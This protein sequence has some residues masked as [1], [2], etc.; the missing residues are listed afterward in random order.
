MTKTPDKLYIAVRADIPP[1]LQM[2]QA[3]HAAFEFSH[4]FPEIT[5]YWL[6]QSNYLVIVAAH[7]EDHLAGLVV[8][9][10]RKDI[11]TVAVREPDHN[12]ELMAVAFEPGDAARRMLSSLPCALREKVPV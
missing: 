3:V 8:E 9:S 10:V 6:A 4:G 11:R 7:D 1:G 2:A 5:G 12:D